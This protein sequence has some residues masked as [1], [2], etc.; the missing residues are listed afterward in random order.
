MTEQQAPHVGV[1]AGVRFASEL[2]LLAALAFVGAAMFDG[3]VM[4]IV[5][6]IALPVAA[7]LIWGAFVA[8]RAPRHL[9]DPARTIVEVLL[10]GVAVV[11]LWV[12]SYVAFAIVL[13]VLYVVG[14]FHGRRAG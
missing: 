13:A 9:G 3:L 5:A 8:P 6:G 10:F 12:Y 2:A 4:S 14:L 1:L 11:G 7:A